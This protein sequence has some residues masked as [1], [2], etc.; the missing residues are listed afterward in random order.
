M[1]INDK[2]GIIENHIDAENIKNINNKLENYFENYLSSDIKVLAFDYINQIIWF[3]KINIKIFYGNI[4]NHI[5]NYLIQRRN[6]MRIFIKKESFDFSDLNKFLK[7]FINKLEY[8]NY[9]IKTDDNIIIKEGIKQLTN[10]II[11]DSFILMF[12]EEQ[13]IPLNKQLITDIRTFINLLKQ[14][15]KYDNFEIFNKIITTFINIFIKQIIEIEE[16]PLPENIKRIHKFNEIIKYCGKI[17]E[18]C[19]F[20]SEDIKQ[21]NEHF[22]SLIIENLSI[23]IKYNSLDEIEYLFENTWNSINNMVI[24]ANFNGKS[25]LL[26]NISIEIINLIDRSLKNQNVY[27]ILKIISI[28]KY[29]DTI[30]NKSIYNEIINQKMSMILC[31]EQFSEIIHINIDSLI[32]DSKEKDV[33]TLLNFVSNIKDKDIFINN[34]Y[35]KLIIRLMEKIS[36][37]KIYNTIP[38]NYISIE[39]QVFDFLKSKFD[40]KLV[41]KLNKVI[42]DTELSFEDNLN[43]NKINIDGFDNK[44][45]VIMTSFNNWDINQTEGIVNS[46]IVD[47]IINTK[48]GNHLYN[49]QLYYNLKHCKKRI[50][51]WFP[52]FGEVNIIYLEKE[53]K[54]LPIQFM[55]LELFN[56]VNCILVKDILASKFFSNYTSK[57]TNDIISS[58]ISSKLFEISNGSLVLS[59]IDNF[60]T[61]LIE[62]FFSTSKYANIWEQRRK[63]ELILSREEVVCANI[64]QIIKIQPMTKTKLFDSLVKVI[65]I[66]ELEQKIFDKALEHMCGMDYIK[67]NGD[68]YE[69][70]IY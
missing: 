5:K 18:Y 6:N 31:S 38:K 26:N 67:L 46:K 40:N 52:H 47:S 44:M 35:K 9:I 19:K 15:S 11:S 10:L 58:L 68:S 13:I 2:F 59:S 55:V 29:T 17:I 12:I 45:T 33:I 53:I 23:I 36:E 65:K 21:L 69:K 37:F 60:N 64:N 32:R 49:Y 39:K 4:E 20:M 63:D 48:L 7:N 16:Q 51:N 66:F 41:Y 3:D 57:F 34:Y 22:Y 54:M 56:D 24:E 1:S 70:I 62:E 50:I 27:N 14:L 25:E 42:V 28:L 30:I 61:N 8:L 43:F